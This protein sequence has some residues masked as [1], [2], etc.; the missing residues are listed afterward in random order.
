VRHGV[1]VPVGGASSQPT[2]AALDAGASTGGFTDILLRS[3]AAHVVAVTARR[4]GEH[5]PPSRL[6]TSPARR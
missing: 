2:R 1:P 5:C 4:H 6:R 3:G